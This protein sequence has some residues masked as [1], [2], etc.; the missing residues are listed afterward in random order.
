MPNE[1]IQ[2][3]DVFEEINWVLDTM[4]IQ[5]KIELKSQIRKDY[6]S[7]LSKFLMYHVK[8]RNIDILRDIGFSKVQFGK[9]EYPLKKGSQGA[10]NPDYLVATK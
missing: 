6:H 9:G 1:Y 8:I 2:A 7:E 10:M 5:E 4:P 3:T